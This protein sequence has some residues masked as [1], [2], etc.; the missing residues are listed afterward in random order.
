MVPAGLG[1]QVVGSILRPSSFCGC[2]G[3]KPT[4]GAINRSGSHDHFSQSCQGA[5]GAS[6][7]DVWE[8]LRAISVRA[9]GDPGYVGLVGNA[10]LVKRAKPLRLAV[11]E[12]AG[13]SAATD[14]ARQAFAAACDRFAAAGIELVRRAQAPELETLEQEITEALPLTL[15]INGWEGRW[16]LNTYRD[17]DA[18][19][20]SDAAKERLGL[21]E[22]MTQ[23]DY[24]ALIAKRATARA[25][26]AKAIGRYDACI[27]LGACGAAP[28]GLGATGNTIMNV[29]ASF[30]G[31]PA[32]TVPVLADEG[33]PLGLQL[34]GSADRDA[35]LFTTAAGLLAV[36]QRTDLIGAAEQ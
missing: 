18:A 28:Q 25:A 17:L 11:L 31:V 20:L 15:K 34:M 27:T 4:V 21:A 6:L 23:Q 10:D 30:L 1:T 14:G 22:Q 9:G 32:L 7:G 26:F 13:W 8:V 35:A 5:L 3:F 29:A 16:P 12:T 2:V 33:L 36:L 24:A 19:K